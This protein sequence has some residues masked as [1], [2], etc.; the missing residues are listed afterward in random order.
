MRDPFATTTV[1]AHEPTVTWYLQENLN[2]TFIKEFSFYFHAWGSYNY[3]HYIKQSK[4]TLS[5]LQFVTLQVI[6]KA[7]NS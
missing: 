4:S 2:N 7:L 5:A 3:N 6:E 1:H